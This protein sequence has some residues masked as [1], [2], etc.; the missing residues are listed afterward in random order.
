MSFTKYGAEIWRDYT[1]AGVPA[2]GAWDVVKADMRAWMA[3]VE[4]EVSAVIYETAGW[5][6]ATAYA[7]G[8]VV[9]Y[10]SADYACTVAHTSAAATEPGVGASWATVWEAFGPHLHATGS[11]AAPGITFGADTDTGF[12]RITSNVMGLTVGGTGRVRI[13]TAAMAPVSNDGLALGS[14]SLGWSDIHVAS[15]GVINWANGTYTITQSGASLAFSGAITLGT[16]LAVTEGGTGA[17]DAA[18]ARTSLGLVIG[19]NVQAYD[20]TLAS[21]AAL[22]TVAD[23]VAYTTGVDTWAETPLT[24]FGRSLID[25]AAAVNGRATLGLASS[26]TD[27]AIARYD[28]TAGQTQNSG[29]TIDDNN[30][31]AGARNLALSGYVDLA[32]IAAPAN[33][34]ANTARFY[35]KDDGGGT[36]KLYFRDSA[37]TETELGAGGGGASAASQADMESASSTAV[38]SSPGRQHFHPGHPK[39]WLVTTVSAGT[40]TLQTSYNITSI[41]DTNVGVLTVTIATDFSSANWCC[42][43]TVSAA[44]NQRWGSVD[45]D[46]AQAAGSIVLESNST[47]STKDDPAAWYMSGY[48]DMV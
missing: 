4:T 24:S 35:S 6:T 25:D 19:T 15:G 5:V 16:D 42:Q 11:A 10:G 8:D 21:L 36:T 46:S 9:W 41:A 31:V 28:L 43:V 34:A 18:G 20:A 33:P 37:G 30:D 45:A 13:D 38:Y 14:T 48:G 2:S 47:S 1:T 40:P 26:T 12:Y 3:G 29:V 27:N 32:E 22:G 17:S 7:V 39:C 23:R 44:G